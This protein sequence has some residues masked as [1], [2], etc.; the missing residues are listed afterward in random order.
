MTPSNRQGYLYDDI[1]DLEGAAEEHRATSILRRYADE[2]PEVRD[3]LTEAL[4]NPDAREFI[5]RRSELRREV[6]RAELERC[7]AEQDYRAVC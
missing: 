1:V 5:I 6:V 4:E 2:V 7:A 3:L